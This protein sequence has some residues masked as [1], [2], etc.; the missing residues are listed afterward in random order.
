MLKILRIFLRA[1]GTRPLP[2][3]GCLLL[4][5]LAEGVGLAVLLPVMSIALG[6]DEGSRSAGAAVLMDFL[7]AAG[8][9][10]GI[11]ALVTVVAVAIILK[12][13]LLL[14]AMTYVGYSVAEVATGLRRDLIANLL[15]VRWSYFTEQPLGR[16]TNALSVEATRAANAYRVA[17]LALVS[18]VQVAVYTG[19][20]F[21]VSW[22]LALTGILAG[23]AIAL[24][25]GFLIKAA[26][27][28]GRRQTRY[29]SQLITY[30][31]DTLNNIRPL[32][33]MGRETGFA[34]LLDEALTG[35]RKALRRQVVVRQALAGLNETLIVVGLGYG[36][37]IA[38][39]WGKVSPSEVTITVMLL[40]QVL[41]AVSRFQKQ[42]QNAAVQESAYWA[43]ENRVRE[44]AAA[45]EKETGWRVPELREGIRLEGVNFSHPGTPVLRDVTM[46]FPSG[47]IAVLTGPSGA[48]KTTVT[49]LVIGFRAP[50]SGAVLIDGHPLEEYQMRLWRS[51][52]GYVPQEL[53]LFYDTILANV[54]LGDPE[55]TEEEVRAALRAAGAL[56]FVDALPEVIQT[57]VGEKGIKM[58][59]GQRQRIALARA[60]VKKP[61]LLILDE[62]TSA[63]DPEAEAG[64]VANIRA[65][66]G[67]TTVIAITHRP[68]FLSVADRVYE[69][70]G[71]RLAQ[72][73]GPRPV[74][75]S[76]G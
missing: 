56:G 14:L 24:V 50:D 59:G 9:P 71:G 44:T 20:A 46:E 25:L 2:V 3:L 38:I 55:I 23:G 13:L 30:L 73:R 61:R 4:G 1:R 32:K 69:L 62:V 19:V 39:T 45:R 67:E 11:F 21:F 41:N 75:A 36:L 42:L 72:G 70:Q 52:I 48:G 6:E 26:K 12:N 68:A 74:P 63:L 28:A 47:E 22:K 35:L 29:T 65:L 40:L 8:L 31:A 17:A 53:V 7:D 15:R 27:R 16:L 57:H 33:A 18:L 60:L 76:L 58:S 43:V 34:H 66:R 49:D 10:T 37:A 54:A 64:I 51:M 5:T